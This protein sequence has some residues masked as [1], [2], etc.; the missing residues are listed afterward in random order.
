[1]TGPI[2]VLIADD[3]RLV[4]SA[5]GLILRPMPDIDVVA[6][7]ADGRQA[8]ELTVRHRPDVALLDIRMPG[9]DGLGAL[10]E[11]RRLA[12][13]TAVIVLTTFG[14]DAYVAEALGDGAAGF[15]LKDSAPDE[16][17]AAVR[18]VAA[19]DA[20]LSPAITRLVL[21]RLPAPPTVD[22][23]A[24]AAL[25]ARER[26]VLVLLGQGLSNA[27]IGTRLF[28]SEGTVKT[29]MYRVFTKLGCESRVQA[30]LLAQRAG[31]LD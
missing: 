24:V 31:L 28:V 18:A 4:R 17:P 12:S 9:L 6:E 29:H 19:G 30:A 23:A 11:I 15:L 1:M 22:G 8:V 21:A 27:E 14:E 5:I 2:R 25:S 16:L 7:A 10:R 13:A 26:E 3:D 20:F